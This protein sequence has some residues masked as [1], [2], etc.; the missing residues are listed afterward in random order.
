MRKLFLPFIIILG[1]ISLL[2]RLFYLQILSKDQ[3]VNDINKDLALQ[4]E[5]DY[6]QRGYIYD[7]RY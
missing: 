4:I 5:Y 1:T 2:G 6:P 7:T 3:S